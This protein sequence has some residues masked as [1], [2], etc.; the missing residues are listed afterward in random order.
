GNSATRA[1]K[2]SEGKLWVAE[3]GVSSESGNYKL[4]YW[5][6]TANK[7]FGGQT[8]SNDY[9]LYG[10]I[11]QQLVQLDGHGVIDGFLQYGYTP[12]SRNEIYT[13]IGAG[14]HMHGL[15]T[16][17]AEDDLGIAIARADFHATLDSSKVSETA[18]ELTYRLVATPWFSVQPSFQ[19][20]KNPG[21]DAAAPAIKVGLLRFE[22]TL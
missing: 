13:Y 21:G 4:G 20:I 15:M 2:S 17:R 14:L 12:K 8:F 19:W 18:V 16:S 22:V 5:Q 10:V 6:H 1:F 11:D 3:T 9:G 7:S